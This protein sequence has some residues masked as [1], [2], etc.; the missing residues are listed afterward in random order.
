MTPIPRESQS[1]V[2]FEMFNGSLGSVHLA[3]LLRGHDAGRL[4]TLRKLPSTHSEELTAAADLARSV[5]HPKLAKVL[6]VIEEQNARYLASEHI[7][8]VTLFELGRTASNRQVPVEPSVAVRIISDALNAAEVARVLL[9]KTLRAPVARV[10][11]PEC[12]WIADYGETF[13]AEVLVAPLLVRKPIDGADTSEAAIL[14][15]DVRVA[16]LELTRLVCAGLSPDD[17]ADT[18]L[19]HLPS[20]LQEVLTTALGHGSLGYRTPQAFLSALS[21]L[22]DG[23]IASEEQVAEELQRLMGTVLNVRRQKLNMLERV[24]SAEQTE[25]HSDETR[26]FR[27]A[28]KTEQRVTARPPPSG[29]A[30]SP[31]PVSSPSATKLAALAGEPVASSASFPVAQEQ[32]DEPTMLFRRREEGSVPSPEPLDTASLFHSAVHKRQSLAAQL[33]RDP[34][35]PPAP[36]DP[37]ARRADTVLVALVVLVVLTACMR[38]GWLM[39]HD[40]LSLGAAWHAQLQALGFFQK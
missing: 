7:S 26:F 27:V 9:T 10:L 13:L 23:L 37:S 12:V 5:A 16:A 8:G 18:D 33:A 31:A 15:E 19:S 25:D 40:H 29:V 39:H 35:A 20:E 3:R 1:D 6:G 17:P 38:L 21:A 36:A 28:V 34:E 11:Y 14:A 30:A 22:S 32:P 2:L 4:V 24:A